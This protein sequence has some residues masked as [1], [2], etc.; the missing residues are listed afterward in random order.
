M[1]NKFENPQVGAINTHVDFIKETQGFLLL[2]DYWGIHVET[3]E[4][5]EEAVI[6]ILE[7]RIEYTREI[8]AAQKAYLDSMEKRNPRLKKLN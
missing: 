8:Y 2:L 6:E 4:I 1:R 5:D 7:G 3:E